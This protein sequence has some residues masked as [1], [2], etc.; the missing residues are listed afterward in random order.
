MRRS[1]FCSNECRLVGASQRVVKRAKYSCRCE[2]C[3]NEFSGSTRAAKTCSAACRGMR[4]RLLTVPTA[5]CGFCGNEFRPRN[6]SYRSYC[7]RACAARSRAERQ[8][9]EFAERRDMRNGM[10]LLKR[11][12]FQFQRGMSELLKRSRRR[13]YEQ[14]LRS[15]VCETCSTSFDRNTL[16]QKTCLECRADRLRA[17]KKSHKLKRKDLLKASMTVWE[18]SKLST[19]AIWKRDSKCYLCGR[20]TVIGAAHEATDE[21]YANA[22][23]IVPLSRGGKHC[24][25]NLRI[26]CRKCNLAKSDMTEKEFLSLPP[27]ERDS[28]RERYFGKVSAHG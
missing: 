3:G 26:A 11:A 14:E 4:R 21:L 24:V 18:K 15:G 20:E 23:H 8:I 28:R 16:A 5:T 10:K 27:S 13:R 9:A 2:I 12:L 7:S 6:N 25:E 1:Q 22:D 17:E 19:R